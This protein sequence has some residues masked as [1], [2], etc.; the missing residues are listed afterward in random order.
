MND[1]SSV[2]TLPL[3]FR[4][5]SLDNTSVNI[6]G[7]YSLRTVSR[8]SIE[9][10][11]ITTKIKSVKDKLTV[12]N[13]FCRG[14]KYST[15][16]CPSSEKAMA[17][18]NALFEFQLNSNT[19]RLLCLQAR[20][21]NMSNITKVVKVIVRSLEETLPSSISNKNTQTVPGIKILEESIDMSDQD[22][23]CNVRHL[24]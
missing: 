15:A 18:R 4:N 8:T 21:L 9:L 13:T 3:S 12:L 17:R 14:G 7:K 6:L 24:M 20:A 1:L 5:E 11:R 2:F 10:V 22:M 16:V 23:T 19:G